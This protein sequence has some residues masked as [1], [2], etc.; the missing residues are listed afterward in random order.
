MYKNYKVT[1]NLSKFGTFLFEVFFV[2]IAVTNNAAI[3]S[4]PRRYFV[5]FG[6]KLILFLSLIKTNMYLQSTVY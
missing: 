5:L 1:Y 4:V 2:N 6:L 3:E